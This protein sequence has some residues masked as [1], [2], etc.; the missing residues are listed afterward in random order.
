MK[1]VGEQI[2]KVVTNGGTMRCHLGN[3]R[4]GWNI[5]GCVREFRAKLDAMRRGQLDM[6][7][8]DFE[9]RTTNTLC[10]ECG[11]LSYSSKTGVCRDGYKPHF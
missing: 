1:D 6:L 5:R 7:A 10:G 2:A 4:K 9:R 3:A 11:C 8:V